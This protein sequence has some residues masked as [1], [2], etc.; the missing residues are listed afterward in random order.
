[1]SDE[2]RGYYK[3]L[4]K[5]ATRE[6]E[7]RLIEYRATGSWTPYR[8]LERFTKNKNGV[9]VMMDEWRPGNQGP[10]VRKE[11]VEERN[12]LE[13]ELEGYEQVIFAPR[14]K[15]MEEEHER[16]VEESKAKR[17]RKIEEV[18]FRWD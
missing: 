16:K 8:V 10:W 5:D 14:P 6:Y 1:M 2:E 3:R 15:E 4:A 12:E 11:P 7:D 13:R 17:R 9:E 18:G